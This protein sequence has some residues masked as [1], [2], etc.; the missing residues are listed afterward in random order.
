[1]VKHSS[2][3][4]I[5]VTIVISYTQFKKTS[6]ICTSKHLSIINPLFGKQLSLSVSLSISLFV[7]L[8]FVHTVRLI[9][10]IYHFVSL[11]TKQV[12]LCGISQLPTCR[13]ALCD[14]ECIKF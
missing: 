1:M 9:L 11:A 7:R 10:S 12:T 3:L 5:D 14:Y 13:Y 6:P 4:C 2:K 8:A